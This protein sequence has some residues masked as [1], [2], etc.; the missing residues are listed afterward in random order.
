[1][2]ISVYYDHFLHN[3]YSRRLKKQERR[4]TDGK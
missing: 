2:L 3:I 4:A 1:M